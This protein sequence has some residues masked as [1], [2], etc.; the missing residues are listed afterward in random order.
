MTQH[1]A[2]VKYTCICVNAYS[3]SSR[4]V[5]AV[6]S[7][8]VR[9]QVFGWDV[10]ETICHPVDVMSSSDFLILPLESVHRQALWAQDLGIVWK[11]SCHLANHIA[12]IIKS[13]CPGANRNAPRVK[14]TRV[15]KRAEKESQELETQRWRS[16]AIHLLAQQRNRLHSLNT[17]IEPRVTI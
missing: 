14:R 5:D 6:C 13:W 4:R 2:P 17:F 9:K 16:A 8:R 1:L 11:R 3:P 15:Q 10:F 7:S 12:K